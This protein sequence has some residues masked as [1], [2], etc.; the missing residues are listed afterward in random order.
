V[1]NGNAGFSGTVGKVRISHLGTDQYLHILLIGNGGK[2]GRIS[3]FDAPLEATPEI[4]LPSRIEAEVITTEA[5]TAY[6][7]FPDRCFPTMKLVVYVVNATNRLLHLR[8]QAAA[9]DAQQGP[10]LKHPQPGNMQ[11]Q[12]LPPGLIDELVQDWVIEQSPPET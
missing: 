12:V 8:I 1:R 4:E 9:G 10:T 3:G 5:L 11:L 7:F 2:K 6:L